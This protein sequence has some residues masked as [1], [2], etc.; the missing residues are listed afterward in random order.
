M[1]ISFGPSLLLLAITAACGS[2]AGDARLA[3]EPGDASAGREGASEA[4]PVLPDSAGTVALAVA[5][6]HREAG[7]RGP[8]RVHTFARDSAGVTVGIGLDADVV[9]GG[10]DVRVEGARQARVVRWWQ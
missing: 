2:G 4:R 5:A 6:Y 7:T 3:A 1:K 9:G 8:M 10:A